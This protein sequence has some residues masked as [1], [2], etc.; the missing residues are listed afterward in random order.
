MKIYTGNINIACNLKAKDM[1]K[2][3]KALKY[4]SFKIHNKEIKTKA[5][6]IESHCPHAEEFK[7]ND[8][9]ITII[10]YI[11]YLLYLT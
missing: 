3:M 5:V 10:V 11:S 8:G 7:I 6:Y 9:R 2:K 4:F 1:P